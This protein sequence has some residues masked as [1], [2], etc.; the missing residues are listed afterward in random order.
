MTD[1]ESRE[2]GAIN[3]NPKA[4]L[5]KDPNYVSLYRFEN[6]TIPYDESREGVVSKSDLIGN[7]YTASLSDLKTYTIQRIKGQRGGRFVVIRVKKEDLGKY[8]ATKLPQTRDMDIE[9][10]N[11]LIPKDVASLSRIEVDGIFKDEWEGKKNLDMAKWREI[12][13]YI[14]NT[15]TDEAI[16]HKLTNF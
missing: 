12:G 16:L 15:L 14:N 1:H 10:G 13:D 9:S 8:D 6:P 4:L 2:T 7:W 5:Y 3:E 11:Y